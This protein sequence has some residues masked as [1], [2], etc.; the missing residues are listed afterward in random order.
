MKRLYHSFI[1]LS[2]VGL[3]AVVLFYTCNAT[4]QKKHQNPKIYDN[5]EWEGWGGWDGVISGRVIDKYGKPIPYATVKIHSKNLQTKADK[6]GYF[7]IKGLQQGGHYSLIF[8]AKGREPAAARWIPIPRFQSADI[9]NFSLDVEKFW[10]NFWVV[11]TTQSTNDVQ[12]VVSNYYNIEASV[13]TIFS[14]AEWELKYNANPLLQNYRNMP[15]PSD[16]LIDEKT[17]SESEP[18]GTPVTNST[19]TT[20][21]TSREQQPV[22]NG[23]T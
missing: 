10:T 16:S 5:I 9:G 8:T 19:D 3:L 17:G 22:I 23:G 11:S 21:G 7:T 12:N 14:Y 13:T 18:P 15:V 1:S 20:T 6:N 4:A 2:F